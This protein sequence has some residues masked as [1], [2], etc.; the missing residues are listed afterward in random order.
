MALR[1]NYEYI[2]F[3]EEPIPILLIELE[4]ERRI[5]D[6]HREFGSNE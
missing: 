5:F 4:H 3:R 6:S 1:R 2:K